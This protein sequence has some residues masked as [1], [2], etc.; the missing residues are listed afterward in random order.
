MS[1]ANIA[2]VLG[3]HASDVHAEVK[4]DAVAVLAF[5][6]GKV[7]IGAWVPD[8]ETLALLL[9][10]AL[11]DMGENGTKVIDRRRRT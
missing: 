3:R 1:R 4:A 7:T 6:D 11:R 9:Q 5:V 10:R 2:E 8:V